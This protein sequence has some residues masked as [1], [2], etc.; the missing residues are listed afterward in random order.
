MRKMLMATGLPQSYERRIDTVHLTIT[1]TYRV[2][3]GLRA[4]GNDP[5]VFVMG[6]L[7]QAHLGPQLA[8]SATLV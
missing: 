6:L 2:T 3:L 4:A 7:S 5:Y 1:K 8:G